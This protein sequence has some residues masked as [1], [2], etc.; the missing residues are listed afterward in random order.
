MIPNEILNYR[1]LRQIGS[2]GMGQV[3]LAQNKDINQL[4]AIKAL[5][6]QYANNVALRARFKQEAVMLSSLNHPNIVKFLNYVENAYGVFLIMEYVEGDTLEDFIS[7][8][9]GLIVEKRA[10]PMMCQ[11]LD[12]FAYAHKRGI[13]HRDIKPSNIFLNKE[14]QI[15]VMDFGIA[16]ILSEASNGTT[17]ERM[18]TP[19][20]MSPEQVYGHAV[21][22]RSDIY[23]LGILFHQMLTG[24]APYDATTLSELE[25]KRRVI[26]EPLPR[27]KSYYPYISEGLQKVVDKA[28]DKDPK[29]RYA[30]CD[31][32]KK[33]VKDVLAPERKSRIVLIGAIALVL[34]LAAVGFGFWDYYRTKVYYYKDYVEYY[35]IPQGIG[36]LSSSEMSHREASYR[37][38]YSRHKLR[39]L[40]RVNSRGKTIGHSDTEQQA[41]RH[42]DVE[43]F[44]T[45]NDQIDYTKI[46]NEYGKLL[47]KLDYDENLKTATFKY[48]DEYGTAM[49]LPLNTTELYVVD[50]NSGSIDRSRI[51]R[52][53][54]SFDDDGRLQQLLYAG[55]ENNDRV[56]D[57]DNIYGMAYEYDDDGHV[58]TTKF[59]GPDGK[60]CGNK[61][62]LAIKKFTYDDDDNWTSVSYYTADG[63]PSHDGNNCARVSYTHDEYGNILTEKYTTLDDK[64]V[65]R[66]DLAAFGFAYEYDEGLRV[67]QTSLD[68]KGEPMINKFGYASVKI[69]HDDNGFVS[70]LHYLDV[71]GNPSN[72]VDDGD[73]YSIRKFK[74]N[75][76]GLSL[77]D[78]CYDKKGNPI[79]LTAGFSRAVCEYD[80]VGNMLECKFYD[81]K[82]NVALVN[83]YFARITSTY[84]DFY[85]ET[86]KRYYDADGKLTACDDGTCGYNV[87][88]DARGNVFRYFFISQDGKT[89]VR[90]NGGFAYI[91]YKYDEVGNNTSREFCDEKG[92]NC[93]NSSGY[94][95]VEM[96]YDSKTNFLKEERYYNLSA[97]LY[98]THYEYDSRGNNTKEY[99]TDASG[100]L[101]AGT[102]VE[103]YSYDVNNYADK[104]WATNMKGVKVNFPQTS[105]SQILVERDSRGNVTK[106]T[107]L[108]TAG[109][110]AVDN[111][112]T[113]IRIHEYNDAN[114]KVY[115]KNLGKDGKPLHSSSQD[116]EGRVTYDERGN[117][118]SIT[119]YDG[120]GKPRLSSDGYHK[121]ESKYDDHNRVTSYTYTDTKG[122]LVMCKSAEAAKIEMAYDDKG[123]Q[124]SKKFYNASGTF[125][126][127]ER[128]TYNFRNQVTNLYNC[129][130]RGRQTNNA[131]GFSRIEIVYAANGVTP[132]YRCAY[133]ASGR[134]LVQQNFNARTNDWM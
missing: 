132:R 11:I 74:N 51:S 65:L 106:T 130:S 102:V 95:R 46:Y 33:A 40:T 59:L 75:D 101:K 109:A 82:G 20:Y 85:R 68:S 39:R 118:T 9:N 69:E 113:H 21:D 16:Q 54:L 124:T 128:M 14:G 66:R 35:G 34:I 8:K 90:C 112:G 111:L 115:E 99:T 110:P 47:Y 134:K 119:C 73:A 133:D 18:G 100:H 105:F 32:M 53:L 55:G 56:G 61:I 58:I 64:P 28:T 10:Y 125:T 93:L 13:V 81:K 107:Y 27:L 3:Y 22:E 38:E 86:T 123:N 45:D 117:M 63:S 43:Y 62:G 79:D 29:K 131:Y 37:M 70:E 5:H 72:Y 23:S 36:E 67:K 60:V 98:T 94:H 108:S 92:G 104:N 50:R 15:K 26:D 126:R 89:P 49:R 114:L 103:N 84:D 2:G 87:E 31:D 120:Y 42:A 77:E 76:V 83:G 88:Y 78:A 57:A 127:E 80:S 71:K 91:V 17:K 121:V 25:I 4:V 12:A 19:E 96:V 116:P 122:H 7:K 129:D 24:R 6:P 30:N 1:I 97:L 44:Y 48:D 52:Y 41:T